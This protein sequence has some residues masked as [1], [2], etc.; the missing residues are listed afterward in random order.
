[1]DIKKRLIENL[2]LVI[3]FAAVTALLFNIV[4]FIISFNVS[5]L[6]RRVMALEGD[7]SEQQVVNKEFIEIKTNVQLTREDVKDIKSYL[8][9]R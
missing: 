6:E 2:Q 4:N 3:A 9:I 8:G 7:N 1:M 5:P